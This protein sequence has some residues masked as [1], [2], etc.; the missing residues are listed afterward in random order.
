MQGVLVGLAA[1]LHVKATRHGGK[2]ANGVGI[3]QIPQ[4]G[5][6]GPFHVSQTVSYPTDCFMPYV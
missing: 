6:S 4:L 5:G 3:R 1:A 2:V